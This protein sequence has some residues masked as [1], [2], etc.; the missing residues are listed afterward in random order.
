MSKPRDYFWV[1][2]KQVFTTFERFTA[3]Q[4]VAVFK[5][6]ALTARIGELPSKQ[7]MLKETTP[8]ILKNIEAR[9]NKPCFDIFGGEI[10]TSSLQEIL[11]SS[12]T[13]AKPTKKQ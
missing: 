13:G 10:E 9:L 7:Q 4:F 11:A 6:M 5:L 8:C 1:S 3:K 2:T 12:L